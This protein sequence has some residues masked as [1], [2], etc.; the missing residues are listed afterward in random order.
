MFLWPLGDK[1]SGLRPECEN[2]AQGGIESVREK[3]KD[4]GRYD[5][6]K[7]T[8]HSVGEFLEGSV[9]DGDV[10]CRQMA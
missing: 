2:S 10:C 1:N 9:V 4:I 8:E 7:M 6:V 3:V 5:P